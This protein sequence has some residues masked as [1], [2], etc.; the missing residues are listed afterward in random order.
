MEKINENDLNKK[1]YVSKLLSSSVLVIFSDYL[2]FEKQNYISSNLIRRIY[3][4]IIAM[5]Q[6]YLSFVEK[7]AI[8]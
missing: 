2:S 6:L 3:N 5:L 8:K 4:C 1:W 7:K